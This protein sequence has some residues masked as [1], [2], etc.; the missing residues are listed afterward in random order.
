[1]SFW[2]RLF[3]RST[4]DQKRPDDAR[5]PYSGRT[6]AGVPMTPDLALQ[7]PA[8]WACTKYIQEMVAALPW[9]VMRQ[10]DSGGEIAERH[11]I[12]GLID[13][14]VNPEWN[15][16]QFRETLLHWALLWGNGYAEI[17]RDGVGRAIALWPVQP[18]RVCVE[19]DAVSRKLFYE[20]TNDGRDRVQIPAEDMFHLRGF[21]HEPVGLSVVDYAA[22][23]LGLARA[24]QLFGG[25]FFGNGANL[26]GVVTMEKTLTDDGFARV[27]ARFDSLYKGVRNANKVAVLDGDMKFQP[28]GVDPD[29]AQFIGTQQ[30]VIEDICRLFSVPPHV[31]GHLLRSTN[32][33][34][35]HQGIEAV[36]RCLGPWVRRLELEA[37]DKLFSVNRRGF[38]TKM[39]MNALLRGDV[40]SR[41]EFYQLMFNVGAFSPNDIL[42]LEDMNTLG[43][44]GDKHLVQLNLTTL[45]KAGEQPME[46]A[47]S[48]PEEPDEDEVA[49]MT[50]IE[51]MRAEAHV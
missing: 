25:A 8:V 49:A 39:N 1:M 31:A 12:E 43:G 15:S 6:L 3:N 50:T 42:R 47:P 16:F 5:I 40:K 44:E 26:S 36:Q 20:V 17:E 46:T 9:H 35:E 22:Q 10:T 30:Q 19:R 34:I 11:P 13:G 14:R 41:G 7:I 51:R 24:V 28:I 48:A 21:G 38:Y 32:N 2:S 45:D 18:W 4:K 33:N 27:K 29:K 23:T 37:N